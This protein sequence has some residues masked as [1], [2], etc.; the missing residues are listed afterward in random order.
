MKIREIRRQKGV[1]Q[2]DLAKAIGVSPTII[3]RYEG[4]GVQPPLEKLQKIATILDVSISD[5]LGEGERSQVQQYEFRRTFESEVL[6]ACS[7]QFSDIEISFENFDFFQIER[8]QA[9]FSYVAKSKGKIWCF[10]I[11]SRLN[12]AG[13]SSVDL[14]VLYRG[15]GAAAFHVGVNKYSII[16][17]ISFDQLWK[18]LP[19]RNCSDR[20]GFDVSIIHFE[21]ETCRLDD[22]IEVAS[23]FDGRGF[24]DLTVPGRE[25]E[26]ARCLAA[27]KSS[28]SAARI[29]PHND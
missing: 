16:T 12:P 24:F 4:G 18:K 17:D 29:P 19:S 28:L 25:V 20:I 8:G 2:A 21:T 10:D 27:W 3:S 23:H 13:I 6:K 5:L 14:E 26:S 11:F 22:E 1:T 7:Q 15:I 9:G